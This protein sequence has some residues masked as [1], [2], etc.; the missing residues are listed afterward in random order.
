MMAEGT[1]TETENALIE[2]WNVPFTEAAWGRTKV[3]AGITG[4]DPEGKL[5][6]PN[7]EIEIKV[8][9]Y[10]PK[11]AH[12]GHRH[13]GQVEVVIPIT[14]RGVHEDGF[15]RRFEFGVGHMLFI[16]ANSYHANHNPFEEE[17]RC[18]ILKM[19]PSGSPKV[20][21]GEVRG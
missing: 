4:V 19:P 16:P 12:T 7:D 5:G 3:L 6:V 2:I 21:V 13:P 18:Y 14:G 15:G 20:Q 9:E 17:L 8:T 10:A 1:S 11:Y